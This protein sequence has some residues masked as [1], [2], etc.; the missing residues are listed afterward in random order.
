MGQIYQKKAVLKMT[1]LKMHDHKADFTEVNYRHLLTL[2]QKNYRFIQ[3]HEAFAEGSSPVLIW[4]HD[5]DFSIHRALSLAKIEA[6]GEVSTTYLIHLHSQ[7]YH[8]GEKIIADKIREIMAL[9]H[10]IGLHFDPGF[11]Q[12]RIQSENDLLKWLAWEKR[13]LETEFEQEIKV[14]SW[15]NPD[16][17]GKWLSLDA[18]YMAG[19]VNAYGK[20]LR[21]QFGYCSDSN[22]YWRFERLED[23]LRNGRHCKLHVLTHPGWWQDEVMPPRQ[24]IHRCIDGRADNLKTTY[25]QLLQNFGRLNIDEGV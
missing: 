16:V 25:D 12:E 4:R 13:L 19:M 15:H 22:G 3:L 14:F 6:E 8:W 2:A 18:D 11:Y 9:G 21:E 1:K 17:G 20:S 5:L 24:R 10:D 7:F 23:V